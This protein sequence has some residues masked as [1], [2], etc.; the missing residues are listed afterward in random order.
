MADLLFWAAAGR[1]ALVRDWRAEALGDRHHPGPAI[2]IVVGFEIDRALAADFG[3]GLFDDHAHQGRRLQLLRRDQAHP[4]S[5]A[6]I[7]PLDK[8]VEAGL[9]LALIL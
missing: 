7:D 9:L 5:A 2:G 3:R 1:D 6:G 4:G 8:G